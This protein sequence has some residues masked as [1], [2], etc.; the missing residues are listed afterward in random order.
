MIGKTQ[1]IKYE[2]IKYDMEIEVRKPGIFCVKKDRSCIIID[3]FVPV[4]IRSSNSKKSKVEKY[5]GLK[6]KVKKNLEYYICLGCTSDSWCTLEY[7]VRSEW[8]IN[9]LR[10]S[11]KA[12]LLEKTVLLGIV[13]TLWKVSES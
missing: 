7:Q 6:I 5:Q 10:L 4:D 3:V 11:I 1:N 13:T 8:L 2:K 12:A 9:E